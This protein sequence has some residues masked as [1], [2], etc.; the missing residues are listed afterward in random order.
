MVCHTTRYAIST[1]K[2]ELEAESHG[3]S[4]S[5]ATKEGPTGGR[6]HFDEAEQRALGEGHTCSNVK[7]LKRPPPT[8]GKNF[9]N[10]RAA[11]ALHLFYSGS[12]FST[13]WMAPR[14]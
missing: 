6:M 13:D 12:S 2:R 1:I 3:Y 4:H 5:K 10:H 14:S 8:T 7:H 9:R 11:E